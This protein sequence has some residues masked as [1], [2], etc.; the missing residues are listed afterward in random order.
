M[1]ELQQAGEAA[2]LVGEL[3]GLDPQH[4]GILAQMGH[5]HPQ[6]AGAV[7][8][9]EDEHAARLAAAEILPVTDERLPLHCEVHPPLL[10]Q[11]GQQAGGQFGQRLPQQGVAAGAR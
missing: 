2:Q 6:A 7:R 4:L 8:S 11:G 3:V 1:T 10:V 5:L 9:A